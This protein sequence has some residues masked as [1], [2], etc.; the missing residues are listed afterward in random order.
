MLN[1]LF[2]LTDVFFNVS[3]YAE[4][5]SEDNIVCEEGQKSRA[6]VPLIKGGTLL[7]L[8]ERLTYHKY[9]DPSFVRTFLTTYRSFCKPQEL[10]TLL[11]QRFE[12]PEPPA[13]EE[14]QIAMERGT[15]VVRE[16]LKRFKKEYAQPIQLR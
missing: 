6:G 3:R 14:D 16:D 11:I 10:L 8:I 13:T 15:P 7:K 2:T 1:Y 12:I 4:E 5:D 9:A